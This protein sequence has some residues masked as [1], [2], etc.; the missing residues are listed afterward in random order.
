[1]KTSESRTS[2]PNYEEIRDRGVA[3]AI[4]ADVAAH[5][6][7]IAALTTTGA[8]VQLMGEMTSANF[9]DVL[10]TGG[11]AIL[12]ISVAIVASSFP[13]LRAARVDPV[14]TLRMSRNRWRP[15]TLPRL[16]APY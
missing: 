13:A 10:G 1:M 9:L 6:N 15:P 8:P 16:P 3:A 14:V 7:F 11:V 2:W 5:R 12:V 4:F